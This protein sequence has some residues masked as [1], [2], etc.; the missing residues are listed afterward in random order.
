MTTRLLTLA[1]VYAPHVAAWVGE[2]DTWGR[3]SL[4]GLVLQ[5]I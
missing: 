2:P 4:V 5:Q 1:T 3:P